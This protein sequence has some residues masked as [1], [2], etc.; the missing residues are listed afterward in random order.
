MLRGEGIHTRAFHKDARSGLDVRLIA[1][2]AQ[3]LRRDGI[4]LVHT[5][6]LSQLI[7]GGIAARLAGAKVVHT[8]HEFYTLSRKRSRRLLR[9]LSVLT[10]T[11]TAVTEPV[12]QFLNEQVGI[13]RR[14]L[15]TVHNGVQIQRFQSAVSADRQAFGWRPDDV[16]ITCVGRIEPEKGHR[17]LLEA[18]RQ[19][20][21]RHSQAKLLV[22]GDGVDRDELEAMAAR[23][24]NGSVQFLGMRKDVPELLAASDIVAMAS[25]HEGLPMAALEAM[26]A[27]KPLVATRVGGLPQLVR[28]GQTGLLVPAGDAA[29]LADAVQ[30]LVADQPRRERLAAAAFS[31]VQRQYSFDRTV[32]RYEGVY[33]SAFRRDAAAK[34]PL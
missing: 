3:Q 34:G 6:H 24:F 19:V 7:Y 21:R 13:P 33:Q 9:G 25:F 2:L 22:V 12:M 30:S 8:E 5:H 18:F 20:H 10:E 32:A 15:V 14:K 23:D 26:A 1:R 27:R 16:V 28:E 17:V 31:E 4:H 29:A 11:V